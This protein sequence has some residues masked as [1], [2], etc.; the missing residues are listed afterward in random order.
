M[1]EDQKP[2]GRPSDFSQEIADHICE[3][4]SEGR[5]LRQICRE[6]AGTPSKTTVFRWL[7]DPRYTA[8]RDQYGRARD[9]QA[10][11]LVEECLE[12]ADD[13]SND[14]MER[15]QGENVG[16]T[17]N[18]EHVQ[19]SKLR[20]DQRKWWAARL[21]PKKYGDKSAV[22]H[23]GPDGGPIVTYDAAELAN[24]TDDELSSLIAIQNK[25]AVAGGTKGGAGPSDG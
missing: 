24:L 15:N 13:G 22:E 1:T 8:F 7:A 2:T 21:A 18:G 6:D 12:I 20:C 16:Y 4:L 10:D 5:S 23:S 17:V 14:W 25:I 9:A 3:E 11:A 19:R